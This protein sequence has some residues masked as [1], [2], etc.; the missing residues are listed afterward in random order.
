MV[1][2]TGKVVSGY[3]V[4]SDSKGRN[5]W[6]LLGKKDPMLPQMFYPM[7]NEVTVSQGDV[8]VSIVKPCQLLSVSLG[9][10]VHPA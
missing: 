6:T 7:V 2:V 4:T 3:L 8:L 10:T 5:H 9:S 1:V